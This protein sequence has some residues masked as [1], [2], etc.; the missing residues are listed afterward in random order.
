MAH[1]VRSEDRGCH[2]DPP[3]QWTHLA[4][5][6]PVMARA[7]AGAV[8]PDIGDIQPM[9]GQQ[10]VEHPA[11]GLAEVPAIV[12]GGRGG[13]SGSG[14]DGG[15]SVGGEVSGSFEVETLV[16]A[17]SNGRQEGSTKNKHQT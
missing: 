9:I 6:G 7:I 17:G 8:L 2:G 11:I 3:R 5:P 10:A 15:D 1:A 14:G 16:A 4:P 13:G 12:G